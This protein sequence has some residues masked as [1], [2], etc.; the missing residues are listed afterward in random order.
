MGRPPAGAESTTA[1]TTT[2]ALVLQSFLFFAGRAVRRVFAPACRTIVLDGYFKLMAERVGFG[3]SPH[4]ESPQLIDFTFCQKRENRPNSRTEV[5][6][7]YT[8]A[9]C[10]VWEEVPDSSVK[11]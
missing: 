9:S 3:L 11:A 6:G 7:G 10:S 8:E 1:R 2:G 4:F 5:H